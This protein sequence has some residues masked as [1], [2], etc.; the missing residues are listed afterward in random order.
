[1]A[2]RE[3]PR[4]RSLTPIGDELYRRDE[5]GPAR[6]PPRRRRRWRPATPKSLPGAVALG[7]AKLALGVAAA[8]AVAIALA[9]LAGRPDSTGLYLGGIFCVL[10]ALFGAGGAS[11]D[12][13][14]E[15]VRPAHGLG[16]RIGWL[17]VG[18]ALLGLGAFLDG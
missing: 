15:P 5:W 14:Y 8:A 13:G 7:L 12:A 18:L 11:H 2:D 4:R 9:R 6:R 17:L 10:L 16:V 1:M 3:P